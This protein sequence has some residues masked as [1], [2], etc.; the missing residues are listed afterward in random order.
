MKK[1][2]I[3]LWFLCVF[4]CLLLSGCSWFYAQTP[5]PK[6]VYLDPINIPQQAENGESAA[7]FV[8][9]TQRANVVSLIAVYNLRTEYG[10]TYTQIFSGVILDGD[11]FVLTTSDVSDLEYADGQFVR[12]S[13]VRA[14]LSDA[15]GDDTR[16]LL[17]L[18]SYD[19]SCGLALYRFHDNFYHYTDDA[20]SAAKSGFPLWANFSADSA[21]V[22]D[23][24]IAIGNA[25]G[26]L[27][28]P[29]AGV[30]GIT[31]LQQSVTQ[32]VVSSVQ[33]S[34]SENRPA[35]GKNL[36][37]FSAPSNENMYGGALFDKNGYVIGLIAQQFSDPNNEDDFL[38]RVS[39]AL[40]TDD[41]T[42]FI[43]SV[44][45]EKQF[46]IP[47]TIA[48]SGSQQGAEAA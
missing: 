42:A 23:A 3:S 24:A 27:N 19:S 30:N 36:L 38:P 39:A 45:A 33:T 31:Y 34:A 26:V 15:Y 6:D 18:V 35:G 37:L 4:A 32:G 16:Y 22:G 8:A 28:S 47:Y 21:S 12:P 20:H 17:D 7:E 41:L 14:V 9:R 29:F 1:H 2:F 11:G 40:P 25:V 10:N 48:Q 13:S 5:T 44:S 43:D 46:A